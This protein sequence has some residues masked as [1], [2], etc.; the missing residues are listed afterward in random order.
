MYKQMLVNFNLLKKNYMDDYIPVT[1][2]IILISSTIINWYIVY[3]LNLINE[4]FFNIYMFIILIIGFTGLLDD[5]CGS[6]LT[7]GFK[8]HFKSLINGKLTTGIF[9]VITTIFVSIVVVLELKIYSF[10]EIIINAGII[11]LMTNLLNLLDLRPA[12]SIKFFIGISVLLILINLNYIIYFIPFLIPLIF[13]L[14]YELKAKI[15]LG[16]SGANLLGAVLGFNTVVL[17]DTLFIRFIV[18]LSLIAL[19]LLSEKYS[20]S[21]IIKKNFIL[22]WIDKLGR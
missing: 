22:N 17:L 13:Y 20:Y 6:K 10:S 7:Q 9:K 19:N 2:G 5:I 3:I 21:T 1:G 11:I 16:D 15:M 12:R 4:Q 18:L 14:P 8:G